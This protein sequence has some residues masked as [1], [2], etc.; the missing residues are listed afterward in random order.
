MEP[1]ERYEDLL[2]NALDN[3][4]I[5]LFCVEILTYAAQHDL[6]QALWKFSP[7]APLQQRLAPPEEFCLGDKVCLTESVTIQRASA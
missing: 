5:P 7:Q 6:F 1:F 2:E 3:C 4:S